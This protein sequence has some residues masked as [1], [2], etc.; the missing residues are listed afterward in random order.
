MLAFGFDARV[1]KY[2]F[3]GRSIVS[4][5]GSG[6]SSTLMQA[7]SNDMHNGGREG[8]VGKRNKNIML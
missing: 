3:E 7:Y 1:L 2:F 6:E 5:I 8:Y 4:S